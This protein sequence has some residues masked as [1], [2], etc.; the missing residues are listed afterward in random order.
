MMMVEKNDLTN[1]SSDVIS[2]IA[3]FMMGKPEELRLKH[4]EALKNIQKKYKMK[5]NP[6]RILYKTPRFECKAYTITRTIPFHKDRIRDIILNQKSKILE[7]LNEGF[8]KFCIDKIFTIKYNNSNSIGRETWSNEDVNISST[9]IDNC[10]NKI[11]ENT[12]S[13]I[14]F[15]ENSIIFNNNMKILNVQGF[16]VQV[17]KEIKQ[18]EKQ[19]TEIKKKE[20]NK[21]E[22]RFCKIKRPS[23]DYLKDASD[24]A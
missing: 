18:Q 21:D 12:F 24:F 20:R 7:A 19:Q 11:I 2:N 16:R 6:E 9:N 10:L 17:S 8:E 22:N 4:N 3:S 1:L 15:K 23:N 14:R 13:N 5:I